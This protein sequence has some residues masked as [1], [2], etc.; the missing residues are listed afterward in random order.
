MCE[1]S[2]PPRH[3]ASLQRSLSLE[4]IGSFSPT[5]TLLITHATTLPTYSKLFN[6]VTS[7]NSPK[8]CS[9]VSFVYQRIMGIYPQ[10]DQRTMLEK[11]AL[12]KINFYLPI[13]ML[14]DF[15]IRFIVEPFRCVDRT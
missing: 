3:K 2:L 12:R 1:T 9:S 13:E 5:P 14:A 8:T 7:N 4:T 6:Y 15:H 10:N 11:I